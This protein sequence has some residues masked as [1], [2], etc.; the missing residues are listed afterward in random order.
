MIM[1]DDSRIMPWGKF[2]GQTYASIPSSYLR[3]AAEN[4]DESSERGRIVI[5]ACD[6]EYQERERFNTHKEE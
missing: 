6:D 3:W 2:Q 5:K 1:G 4:F